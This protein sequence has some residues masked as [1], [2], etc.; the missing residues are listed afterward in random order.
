[1]TAPNETKVS[2]GGL[3]EVK[4]GDQHYATHASRLLCVR[5]MNRTLERDGEVE[6]CGYIVQLVF[7][8]KGGTMEFEFDLDRHS[9][10]LIVMEACVRG[11]ASL[12]CD[13]GGLDY[14]RGD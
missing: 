6:E 2:R 11:L 12:D 10:A 14:G 7:K 4:T 3:I 8:D 5:L 9:D 13:C 1:M